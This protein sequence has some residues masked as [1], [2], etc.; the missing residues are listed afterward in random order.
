MSTLTPYCV[1]CECAN[2]I[3]V[4]R[5]AAGGTAVCRCGREVRVPR[6][7][8][9]KRQAGELV[10]LRVSALDR[11]RQLLLEQGL[12][13][14]PVCRITQRPTTDVLY[15]TV[16]CEEPRLRGNSS[17]WGL[18]FIGAG[19]FLVSLWLLPVYLLASREEPEVIAPETVFRLPVPIASDRQAQIRDYRE[20]E[21]RELLCTV[22]LYAQLLA[23]FPQARISLG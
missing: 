11:V 5:T 1:R 17:W 19:A 4:E 21:L 3:P 22:P 14:D 9:L 6:L 16:V 15:L 18:L 12:P 2:E 10:E 23:E 20:S 8:E 13:P 7:S